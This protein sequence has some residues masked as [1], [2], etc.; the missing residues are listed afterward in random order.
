VQLEGSGTFS[1]TEL[2]NGELNRDLLAC[3]V[4]P[5]SSILT[6]IQSISINSNKNLYYALNS[7]GNEI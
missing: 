5:Q 7:N 6:L 2:P 4:A 3:S 1:Y